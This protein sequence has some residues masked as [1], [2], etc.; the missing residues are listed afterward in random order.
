MKRFLCLTLALA[1]LVAILVACDDM[2]ATQIID[3]GQQ[4]M[5]ENAV[6]TKEAQTDGDTA[7]KDTERYPD[8]FES[9]TSSENTDASGDLGDYDLPELNFGGKELII[10]MGTDR[11]ARI[12]FGDEEYITDPVGEQ[13]YYRRMAIEETINVRL[14]SHML[15]DNSASK[16]KTLSELELMILS[17]ERLDAVIMPPHI[18]SEL[19]LR[20]LLSNLNDSKFEY[21]GIDEFDWNES[22]IK[23][24][25]FAGRT[26]MLAGYVTPSTFDNTNV[27]FCNKKMADNLALDINNMVSNGTWDIQAMKRMI[28]DAYCDVNANNIVDTSDTLGITMR[29]QNYIDIFFA[30]CGLSYFSAI[31]GSFAVSN[32]ISAM[33]DCGNVLAEAF[34]ST[35]LL[36][37]N[38]MNVFKDGRALFFIDRISREEILRECNFEYGVLPMPKATSDQEKYLTSA[39]NADVIV[40]PMSVSEPSAISFA[41]SLMHLTA[42]DTIIDVGMMNK[43]FGYLNSTEDV[44]NFLLSI[45]GLMYGFDSLYSSHMKNTVS[46]WREGVVQNKV[47]SNCHLQISA[48]E[49]ELKLFLTTINK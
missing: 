43:Y 26:Y 9:I 13:A 6:T 25:S 40:I 11:S 20:G 37:Q 3:L 45:D 18:T 47:A 4:L 46:S 14:F 32:D 30:S 44:E 35:T 39:D 33:I 28:K 31:N 2:S 15:N 48:I 23:N 7:P 10:A 41:L 34:D 29:T 21:L 5:Q 19:M 36:N 22:V 49:S 27:V 38:T 8:D 1:M 12:D 16:S 17:G 42:V 24:T